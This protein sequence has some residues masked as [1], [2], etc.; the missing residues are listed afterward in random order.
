MDKIFKFVNI[1]IIIFFLFLASTRVSYANIPCKT[2]RDCPVVSANPFKNSK[3]IRT[4]CR[5][6]FCILR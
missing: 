2:D 6:G 1:M 3:P 4:R 5:N